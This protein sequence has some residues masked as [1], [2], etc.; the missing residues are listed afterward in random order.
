MNA[1]LDSTNTYQINWR[2]SKTRDRF[3]RMIRT[4][5]LLK[6]PIWSLPSIMLTNKSLHSSMNSSNYGKWWMNFSQ[7]TYKTWLDLNLNASKGCH[8]PNSS[9]IRMRVTTISTSW[10]WWQMKIVLQVGQIDRWPLIRI[11]VWVITCEIYKS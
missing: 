7:K 1:W 3:Y 6:W 9:W 2:M 10:W 5:D 8:S 4:R 11:R